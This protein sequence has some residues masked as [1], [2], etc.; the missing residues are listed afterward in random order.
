MQLVTSCDLEMRSAHHL[1][2]SNRRRRIMCRDGVCIDV[3]IHR[4][5]G[6]EMNVNARV[7]LLLIK[8]KSSLGVLL[9]IG[10]KFGDIGTT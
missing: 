1:R 6:S 9:R 3:K 10:S 4:G 2:F 7:V 8:V 5:V